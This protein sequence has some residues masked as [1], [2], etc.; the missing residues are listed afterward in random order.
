[1]NPKKPGKVRKVCNAAC[2]SLNDHLLTG[3]DLL[4]NLVGILMRFREE[5]IAISADIEEMSSQ[6][7]V[8][9]YEQA[10]LRFL[11]QQSPESPPEVYQYVRHIFGAKCAPTCSNYALL[12]SAKDNKA[13]F[14]MAVLAVKRNF[15]TDDFF[16]LVKPTF[17]AVELQQE[18]VELLK[19]AGFNLTKWI[20]NSKEVIER[21]PELERAPSI[22][23]VNENIV[24]PV[25]RALGV[26]WDT[27]SDCFAYQ[28][29][30]RRISY[31]R[32]KILSLRSYWIP[33][34]VPYQSKNPSPASLVAQ[35]CL[36]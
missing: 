20:S 16:K 7:G 19:L 34:P 26:I 30:N 27:E 14:P 6:V 5:R 11:W 29:G 24:M 17:E 28:V 25:E 32:R 8:P 4:Q 12:R 36:G 3:P 13:E 15:Y 1:M 22:K 10:C 2:S 35:Y 23:I 9:D 21:I 31:T 18:L 33:G